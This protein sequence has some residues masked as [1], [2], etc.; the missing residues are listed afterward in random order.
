[1]GHTANSD[2][3]YR[4]LQQRL[5]CAVTGAPQSPTLM[6]ILKLLFSPEESEFARRIPSRP[7][8]LDV[9]ARKLGIAQDELCDRMT[10][11]AHRGLMIDF[12]HNGQRYFALPPVVIGLFEFTFMRARDDL[13][14]AELA[15]LFEDYM[16]EDDRFARSVFQGQ[17]QIGR[18][19][20]HEE[21]LQGE[22][23][24]EILDW[25]RASHIVRSASASAVSLCSCRHK[26]SHLGRACDRPQQN[27][28][29]FN[30][31]AKAMIRCGLAQSITTGEAMRILEECKEAGLAQTGDNVRRKVTYIC[32]CCGCCCGMIQA[33][34][35]FDIRNAIVT[36]N[37][38]MEVDLSR[39]KGCGMCVNACP[40]R[41]I[42]IAHQ[43]EGER[44]R[45]WA[46][47]DHTLCLGC[48]VCYSACKSGGISMKPREPRVFTP[49]TIF[50]RIVAM[51]I[52]R[53]K[54]AQI[55]FEEPEK[56]SHRALGRIFNILEKS[57][58]FK[59]AMAIKPLRSAFLNALVKGA[60]EQSGEM[61]D[62][63]E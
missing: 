10:E 11:M 32:N 49:E 41:A 9:L 37:W 27:C 15:R 2:R 20:V 28:L 44:K 43:G 57:P 17:T 47:L 12:E 31:A 6:K 53:G 26:A 45:K 51:A 1:M 3:N 62:L 16:G 50:D 30:Y 46:A 35:T 7:T 18:S 23:L 61:R 36:S 42:E 21:A 60:K 55:L 54:L 52:E 13:P 63:L 48:G 8:P 58:P 56:L 29:S 59:A 5:D 40:V 24:T 33:I 4:L 22:G 19:L 25:E 38:M 34:Q 14:M 39:C